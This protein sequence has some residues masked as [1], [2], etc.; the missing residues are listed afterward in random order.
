MV[1]WLMHSSNKC[2][3]PGASQ[4]GDKK[5]SQGCIRK[6]VITTLYSDSVGRICIKSLCLQIKHNN[7]ASIISSLFCE[8]SML[9]KPLKN[10]NVLHVNNRYIPVWGL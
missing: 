9:S 5:P 6:S 2:K 1:H 8:C 3:I 10:G 7:A 4:R